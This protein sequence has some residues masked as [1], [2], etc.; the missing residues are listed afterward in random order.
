MQRLTAKTLCMTSSEYIKQ[1]KK[2]A[3]EEYNTYKFNAFCN[4]VIYR[5]EHKNCI[6]CV[7][8]LCKCGAKIKYD[9]RD[10]LVPYCERCEKFVTDYTI[11][12]SRT[13]INR[14]ILGELNK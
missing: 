7:H 3:D 9:L 13:A 2:K 10:Y 12:H 11:S 6:H 8:L 4:D 1:S 5:S 14:K